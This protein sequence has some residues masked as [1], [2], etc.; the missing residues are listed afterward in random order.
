MSLVFTDPGPECMHIEE[1][2]FSW[3]KRE[4]E[5]QREQGG[6]GE[7]G[8]VAKGI[9]GKESSPP[10]SGYKFLRFRSV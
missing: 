1:S 2:F 6:W 9:P 7:G 5:S 8:P 10:A 3:R 4:T